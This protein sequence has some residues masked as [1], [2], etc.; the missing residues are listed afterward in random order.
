MCA[1]ADEGSDALG[2]P[3]Y[4]LSQST[5]RVFSSASVQTDLISEIIPS[6]SLHRLAP[7]VDFGD[8]SPLQ[9]PSPISADDRPHP[10]SLGEDTDSVSLTEE[11]LFRHELIMR[12]SQGRNKARP[13]LSMSMTVP[14]RTI[15]LT[16][17]KIWIA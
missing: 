13:H 2:F 12:S 7:I 10:N 4:P 11:L 8:N 1:F 14:K 16:S 6:T 5:P 17:R 9:L 3:G 15:L